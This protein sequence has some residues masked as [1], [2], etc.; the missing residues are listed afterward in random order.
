MRGEGEGVG[1]GE[2]EGEGEG[3][4]LPLALALEATSDVMNERANVDVAD[5]AWRTRDL[6]HTRCTI[7]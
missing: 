1:V 3:E 2:G 4:G 5:R 7:P 6:Y